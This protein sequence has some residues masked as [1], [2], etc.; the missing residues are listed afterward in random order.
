MVG[1]YGRK[2]IFSDVKEITKGNIVKVLENAISVHQF[3]RRQIDFLYNYKNGKQPILERKKEIRPEICNKIVVNRANEIV[4]FKDSYLMGKPIQ[5]VGRTEGEEVTANIKLLNDYMYSAKKTSSDKKLATWFHTCGVAYRMVLPDK[6]DTNK[7]GAPFVLRVLDPRNTFLIKFS[8]IGN[9]VLAGVTYVEL[10]DKSVLYS[11]YTPTMYFELLGG[12]Q[13][14]KVTNAK[15]HALGQIPIIEYINNEARLGSFEVVL[16]L[17]NAINITASNRIDGIEQFIQSLMVLKG[18]DIEDEQFKSLK[19]LGGIKVPE[20]GDVKFLIQELNQNQTQVVIDD[21][22]ETILTICGMPNRNGGS[23]TSDT[24]TAVIMRDG[25]GSAEARAQETQVLFEDSEK[26]FL[27]IVLRILRDMRELNL[28]LKDVD[29]RF[30]R[31]N[32]EN[33]LQKA[34]VLTTMLGNENIHP[35]LAYTHCGMFPDPELAY[36]MSK[37]YA[38]EN[39]PVSPPTEETP[40]EVTPDAENN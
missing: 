21:M 22:Y 28:N 36:S 2:E 1:Y 30:T 14:F 5:Y 38:E 31:G 9:D 19:E 40:T 33:I 32:Y 20:N 13:T 29:I 17:L 11:V 15:P 4:S 18:V 25:W 39:K 7:D 3:N 23:S 35:L 26:D 24:G 37:K 8:G 6:E 27:K 10:A 16:D 12:M 34:T